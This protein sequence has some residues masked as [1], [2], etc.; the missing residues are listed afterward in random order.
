[1]TAYEIGWSVGMR[2]VAMAPWLQKLMVAGAPMAKKLAPV[3][4]QVGTAGVAGAR[5][6]LEQQLGKTMLTGGKGSIKELLAGAGKGAIQGVKGSDVAGRAGQ[7]LV[8]PET[9][10]MLSE[11]L[12]RILGQ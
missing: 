7:E 1:M 2:K 11:A 8:N 9:K 5:T 12:A 10:Q 4:K 3:A 6:G